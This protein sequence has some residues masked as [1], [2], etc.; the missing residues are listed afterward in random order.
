MKRIAFFLLLS[1]IT[2]FSCKKDSKNDGGTGGGGGGSTTP[3]AASG[4]FIIDGTVYTPGTIQAKPE[5]EEYIIQGLASNGGVGFLQVRLGGGK[6][7][8]SGTYPLEASKP[9]SGS[10]ESTSEGKSSIYTWGTNDGGMAW[11]TDATTG[12]TIVTVDDNKI[13]VVI[14]DAVIKRGLEDQ[15]HTV[16]V[17][18]TAEME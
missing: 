16:S 6:P 14:N 10:F 13:T 5:G 15:S 2:I 17:N 3:K 1:S 7:E 11:S 12:N 18:F 4:T 9:T 8:N